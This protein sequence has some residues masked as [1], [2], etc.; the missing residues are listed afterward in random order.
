MQLE[1]LYFLIL[2]V[3]WLTIAVE[4]G[5]ITKNNLMS[6]SNLIEPLLNCFIHPIAIN[7]G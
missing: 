5:S 4:K 1:F 6:D 2:T 7:D 3:R